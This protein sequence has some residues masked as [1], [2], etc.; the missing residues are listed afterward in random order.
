MRRTPAAISRSLYLVGLLSFTAACAD[1]R[2]PSSFSVRDS[3]GIQISESP[4]PAWEEGQRWIIGDEPYLSI[5]ALDGPQEYLFDRIGKAFLLSD[6]RIAVS[7][8]RTSEIR[9]FSGDGTFLNSVGGAGEGPG[10]FQSIQMWRGIGDTIMVYDARLNRVSA[11]DPYGGFVSSAS[12]RGKPELGHPSAFGSTGDGSLLITSGTGS[13]GAGASGLLD[14][15]E[16]IFSRHGRDGDFSSVI[17]RFPADS[18]WAYTAAGRTVPQYL[19][20]SVGW[21]VYGWTPDRLYLGLGR[22]PELEVWD[23]DGGMIG[24][25]RWGARKRRVG[26]N[27]IAEYRREWLLAYE[28]PNEKRF[29]EGWLGEVPFPENLPVFDGLLVDRT[30]HLWIE[31]YE[32]FWDD[33]RSWSVLSPAGS[34]LGDLETPTGLRITEIGADYLLGVWR[35]EMDVEFVRL[36]SLDHRAER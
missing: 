10:E 2:P 23:P 11:L 20:H 5:G 28:D 33:S 27:G 1:A 19:P 31:H 7:N 4:I 22:K 29:W 25:H 36:Y 32:P 35:N 15:N 6:G 21:T 24:L 13:F 26:E 30:G 12:L 34:W 8:R 18:R 16:I 14:G 9:F 3:A 17:S